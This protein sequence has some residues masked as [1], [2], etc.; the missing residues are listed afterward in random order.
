[1]AGWLIS[2]LYEKIYCTTIKPSRDISFNVKR[3]KRVRRIPA[4]PW[5]GFVAG[6]SSCDGVEDQ[7]N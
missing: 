6:G 4:I 3:V 1:M 7:V 2:F 5:Q